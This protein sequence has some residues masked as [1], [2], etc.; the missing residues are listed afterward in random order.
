MLWLGGNLYPISR[1]TYQQGEE[2]HAPSPRASQYG[3]TRMVCSARAVV[4]SEQF[5]LLW[6]LWLFLINLY[7]G[8]Q[9]KS[10]QGFSCI[11][12]MSVMQTLEKKKKKKSQSRV[13][14]RKPSHNSVTQNQEVSLFCKFLKE[15]YNNLGWQEFRSSRQTSQ[16]RASFQ[17]NEV[18]QGCVQ[19][20]F[21]YLQGWQ[22]TNFPR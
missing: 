15:L 1:E 20:S 16:K 2:W 3:H 7:D 9:Q 22:L 18:A 5:F 19:E 4:A 10:L 21:R 17:F 6:L 13:I 12:T 11:Y 8:K 14:S